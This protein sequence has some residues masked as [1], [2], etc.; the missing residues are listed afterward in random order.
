MKIVYIAGARIP[1]EKAHGLQIVKMCQS[2][3]SLGHQVE[4]VLPYRKNKIKTDVFSYYNIKDNFQVKTL[5][6]CDLIFLDKYLG[7]LPFW[8]SEITFAFSL[9]FYL[10]F[11][12][13]DVLYSRDIF[14]LPSLF[15]KKNVFFE[16]HALSG[17]FGLYSFWL[18]KV[19][20]IV[21]ITQQLKNAL[22]TKG[23]KQEKVLVACDGVDLKQ[24]SLPLSKGQARE[25]LQ[26]PLDKKIV[27]YTGHL[28][29]WKGADILLESSKLLKEALFIFVGG[30]DKDIASFKEKANGLSNIL[31]VGRKPHSQ[32][33]LW[34]SAADVL[35]L[36]NTAK[37]EISL[38]WT[39]PLKMFEYMAS[40][41]PI[42]AAD[43]PSLREI[44]NNKNSVLVA[45]DNP[46]EIS[47]GIKKLLDDANLGNSLAKQALDDVQQYDWSKRAERITNF[48]VK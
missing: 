5:P 13:A 45:P 6:A 20:G 1:T 31:I 2:F 33:P 24:F 4:L 36:P 19:K 25:E 11:K 27:L 42:V 47:R 23:I 39:S 10:L 32:I 26:L 16:M 35:V 40:N 14:V 7:N 22:I 12:K 30:T 46:Q 48:M 9:C 3:A 28:Y 29:D 17:H 18:K 37:K 15:F 8:L 43:L 21:A 44:L 38:L 34:L 41:R